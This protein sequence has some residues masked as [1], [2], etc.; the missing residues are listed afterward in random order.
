MTLKTLCLAILAATPLLLCGCDIG[1]S[2]D[3]LNDQNAARQ[4]K[5]TRPEDMPPG[6][7][8][9][10]PPPTTQASTR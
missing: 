6:L 10:L 4:N 7:A 2:N 9:D 3:A 8:P 5:V 1:A